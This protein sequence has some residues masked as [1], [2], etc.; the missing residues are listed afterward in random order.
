MHIGKST[1]QPFITTTT[2]CRQSF[3]TFKVVPPSFEH[4]LVLPSNFDKGR[5][6]GGGH[7]HKII[8]RPFN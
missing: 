3:L 8:D 6:G 7:K 1:F 5:R 2:S 4:G